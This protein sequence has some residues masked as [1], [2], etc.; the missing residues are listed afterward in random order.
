MTVTPSSPADP[1]LVWDEDG[2][3]R[4]GLYGD[5]Y[6]SAED[7]LSETRAVFLAGGGLPEAWAGRASFT[8]AE[9]GFGTGLNIAALLDLWTRAG[10]PG[11]HLH[12]FS[13]EGHPISRDDA[14][15]AL[16][17]W[18]ELEAVTAP[19]L[20][21]WPRRARG[22]HRIDLPGMGVTFDLAV[23]EAAEALSA[24]S[25]R[26]DLW[27]LDGFAPSTNPAMWRQEV[28]DLVAARSAPGG[29]VATFTVAGA[30]RRGLASAGFAVE[31]RP[32]F[33][34][35]RERL[36]ARL[37]GDAS[38]PGPA[39]TVAI[40]G[41]GVAGAALA[42]AFAALGLE[43][44]VFDPDGPGAGASGNAA[45]LVTP[46][47][48]AG[49]GV[50]ARLYAQAF[51]RAV[52][53]YAAEGPAVALA[54]GAL[55]L[56][57]EARDA[58]RFAR[59]AAS[60]LYEPGALALQDAAATT[61][62]LGEAAAGGVRFRDGLVIEPRAL[63]DRWAPAVRRDA[64]AAVRRDEGGWTLLDADGAV[65]ARA[66]IVCLAA[67]HR[68]GGLWDR[69]V[70]QPVRGQVSIASDATV[71]LAVSWGGYAVPTLQGVL[72]G[73]TFDRGRDDTAVAAVD[74]DRNRAL[75]AGTLPALAARL[76]ESGVEG[77]AAVR[78]TTPDHLPIA[79]RPAG[80]PPGL[81]VL[82]GL[83]SR[84]FCTAPLMAEHVAALALDLPSPLPA[85]LA[86]AIDPSRFEARAARRTSP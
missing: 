33:G 24:W 1:D 28:L 70:L 77:R 23:M 16:G 20:A 81:F 6:F 27:F 44:T 31:K 82:G 62:L 57:Q 22:F 80:A 73:A 59:I 84:G 13:V 67:G 3:P 36:E 25:G 10:P 41:A 9:L 2:L 55:L 37:P 46:R 5:V 30:V 51:A 15:R 61:T 60:D 72:Y 8:V 7:G 48:D 39:P 19:L 68:A 35:K 83:G 47:L 29:K 75:L 21:A 53:L 85:D 45:A 69:V 4:S 78:A 17:R 18:P 79:G 54:R 58:A 71:P 64:V 49:L 63:L 26:A 74:H 34:R 86:E 52:D 42:R 14:A 11:G 50:A 38:A 12:I 56:E 76:P 65:I 66:D 40:L 32:G 43:P